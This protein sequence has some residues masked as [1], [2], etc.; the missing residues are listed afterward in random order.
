VLVYIVVL[1]LLVEYVPK[2]IT[3]SFAITIFT[4]WS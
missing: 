3:E 2:V 4:A 1:G